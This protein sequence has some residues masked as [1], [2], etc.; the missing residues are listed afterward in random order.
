M[1]VK[2]YGYDLKELF[3]LMVKLLR[4]NKLAD[5]AL[6]NTRCM[7]SLTTFN[8]VDEMLDYANN[9][10]SDSIII[11]KNG[12]KVYTEQLYL[13]KFNGFKLNE[14]SVLIYLNTTKPNGKWDTKSIRF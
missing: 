1:A 9:T 5:V 10:Y 2:Q 14:K 7:K 13:H 4:E 12:A 3:I 6:L 8:N 11:K